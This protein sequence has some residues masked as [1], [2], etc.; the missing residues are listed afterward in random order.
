MDK[1]PSYMVPSAFTL[2]EALPLNP[3]GKLDRRALPAPDGSTH[4]S[5]TYEAPRSEVEQRIAGVWSV[6]TVDASGGDIGAWNSIALDASSFPRISY[7]ANGFLKLAE[8]LETATD[9]VRT[10]LEADGY[11]LTNLASDEGHHYGRI[12]LLAPRLA[13]Y[14]AE[15]ESIVASL[16]ATT[17]S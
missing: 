10:S 15:P 4:P 14:R 11:E 13:P 17:V 5:A 3:N 2:L 1:L 12:S 8:R 9:M 6:E 16:S 7:H